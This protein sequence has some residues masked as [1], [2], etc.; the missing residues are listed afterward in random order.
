MSDPVLTSDERRAAE[1]AFTGYECD[2]TWSSSARAIY[3][4]I[5]D[6]LALRALR[7]TA[8]PEE[9]EK[10]GVARKIA[11]ALPTGK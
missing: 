5:V 3:A 1:A 2:P 9:H 4:G 8:A 11:L 6:V 10:P 7:Q